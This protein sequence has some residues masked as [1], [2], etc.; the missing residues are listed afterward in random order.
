MAKRWRKDPM[1]TGLA[2]VCAGVRGSDLF[3]GDLLLASVGYS[4]GKWNTKGW[5]WSCGSNGV[6]GIEHRNTAH[7]KVDTEKEAKAAAK[8]YIDSCLRIN[9]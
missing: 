2:R 7:D 6:L 8:K 5:Y 3:D 1:P 4:D 9:K